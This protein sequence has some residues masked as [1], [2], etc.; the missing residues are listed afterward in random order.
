MKVSEAIDRLEVGDTVWVK[1]K[2][3]KKEKAGYPLQLE[4]AGFTKWIMPLEEISLTEPTPID[5]LAQEYDVEPDTIREWLERGH[6]GSFEK[7]GVKQCVAEWYESQEDIN[8]AIFNLAATS[9]DLMP[10]TGLDEF[11]IWFYQDP[12]INFKTLIRMKDGYTIKPKRWVVKYANGKYFVGLAYGAGI[13]CLDKITAKTKEYA[14][15][16]DDKP[17]AEAVATLVEGSVEE[18]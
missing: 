4:F 9:N 14:Y 6:K 8:K 11:E 7:V 16:F 13:E 10:V 12:E 15:P 18:A 5:A 17:K 1:G 3:S 2:V